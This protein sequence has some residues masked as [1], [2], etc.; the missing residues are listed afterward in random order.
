MGPMRKY[1]IRKDGPFPEKYLLQLSAISTQP[2]AETKGL[3]ADG[4]K[5]H[6]K[7]QARTSKHQI[8]NNIKIQI[9]NVPNKVFKHVLNF[10][11]SD[12]FRI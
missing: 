10:E 1:S 3:Y 6:N 7:R 2:S 9:L 4:L 8:L 11:H 5:A 12:L